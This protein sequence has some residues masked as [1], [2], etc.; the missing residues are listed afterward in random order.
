[1]LRQAAVVRQAAA[2]KAALPKARQL[3]R[4]ADTRGP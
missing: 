4:P 1:V 2:V 3:A